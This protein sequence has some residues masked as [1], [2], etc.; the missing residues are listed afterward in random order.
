MHSGENVDRGYV[1]VMFHQVNSTRGEADGEDE[2]PFVQVVGG[3]A[4]LAFLHLELF[5]GPGH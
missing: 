2:G 1:I 5:A 4:L 3:L